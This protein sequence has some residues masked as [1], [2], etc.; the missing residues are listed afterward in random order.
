MDAMPRGLRLQKPGAI[1]DVFGVTG[2]I[3]LR[4]YIRLN[5]AIR[6]PVAPRALPP[7]FENISW[8]QVGD[9]LDPV[10]RVAPILMM[11]AALSNRLYI[12]A[13][14]AN[15]THCEQTTHAERPRAL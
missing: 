5:P 2:L 15:H 13:D 10:A 14:L 7:H 11:I 3:G 1:C 4:I 9:G 12:P 8:L 6:R